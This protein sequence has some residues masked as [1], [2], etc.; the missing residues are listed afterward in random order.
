MQAAGASS[1]L[2]TVSLIINELGIDLRSRWK[3]LFQNQMSLSLS[4]LTEVA[5]MVNP[6]LNPIHGYH[7]RK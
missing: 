4:C 1:N 5:V 2:N 7:L 3:I 6:T